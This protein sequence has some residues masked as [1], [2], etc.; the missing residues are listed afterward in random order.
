MIK[1]ARRRWKQE[2]PVFFKRII[3]IGRSLGVIGGALVTYPS[4]AQI[5]GYV[6]AVGVVMV[7]IAKMTK[8]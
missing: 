3:K 2:E 6:I 7:T 4:T 5:G 8:I 1:E